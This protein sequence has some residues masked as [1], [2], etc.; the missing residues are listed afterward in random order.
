MYI[1]YEGARLGRRSHRHRL[2]FTQIVSKKIFRSNDSR[3]L[4]GYHKVFAPVKKTHDFLRPNNFARIDHQFELYTLQR[5]R[6]SGVEQEL[7]NVKGFY[8]CDSGD[9]AKM[10]EMF[11]PLV[12]GRAIFSKNALFYNRI[13]EV[14]MMGS[15]DARTDIH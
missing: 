14:N 7:S 15:N 5:R 8:R 2:P 10:L 4:R 1:D 13:A 9:S 11:V 3:K 6:A 12:G